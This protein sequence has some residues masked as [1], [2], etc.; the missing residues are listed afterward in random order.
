M[1]AALYALKIYTRDL[2]NCQ[3]HLKIHNTSCLAWINKKTTPNKTIFFI[4]K[5]LWDY[6]MEK[7]WGYVRST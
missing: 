6:Y 1:A 3:I 4:V 2:P 5:E 7:I